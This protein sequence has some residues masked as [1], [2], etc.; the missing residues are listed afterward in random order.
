M[1]QHRYQLNT[2][3]ALSLGLRIGKLNTILAADRS[4]FSYPSPGDIASIVFSSVSEQFQLGEKAGQSM[5]V[6]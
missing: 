5:V 6:S 2:I 4:D 3:M 1:R